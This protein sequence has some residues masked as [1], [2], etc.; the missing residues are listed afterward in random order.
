[1]TQIRFGQFR[2]DQS[3]LQ[4]TRRGKPV[5]LR[6]KAA[7][8]LGLLLERRGQLVSKD[9]LIARAWNGRLVQDQTLFQTISELRRLLEPDQD[10]VN[11][12]NSG[13][14][15]VAARQ[16]TPQA[17]TALRWL[18][19]MLLVLLVGGSVEHFASETGSQA[20]HASPAI[21]AFSM[22]MATL[23][24]PERARRYFEIAAGENR[25]FLEARLMLA[26]ALFSQ[27]QWAQAHAEVAQVLALAR[28]QQSPYVEAG[29]MDL[30]SRLSEKAG[31]RDDALHWA[32]QALDTATAEGFACAAE[33][34]ERRVLDL[35]AR[36]EPPMQS[37]VAP[38]PEVVRPA[39]GPGA[40]PELANDLAQD[41][42]HCREITPGP[43]G[44]DDVSQCL[45]D[46]GPLG[47]MRAVRRL[48][49]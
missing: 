29:A 19:A 23:D 43:V 49:A 25:G 48:Y 4:L 35:L 10:I 12:P 16:W 31:A 20:V 9:E 41:L 42:A 40:A 39:K 7:L 2:F 1:M 37:P 15:L 44:D 36:A 3:R 47:R 46:E 30:L 33:E 8:V 27:Q 11:I 13:Y 28:Q 45:P 34:S 21:R 26:E 38:H 24:Q 5:A 22:G 14:R 6:P 32:E 18:P 17:S